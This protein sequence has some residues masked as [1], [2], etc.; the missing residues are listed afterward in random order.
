MMNIKKPVYKASSLEV[1]NEA[2]SYARAPDTGRHSIDFF[3][4]LIKVFLP[5]FLAVRAVPV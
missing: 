4:F 5:C 1:V 2:E 3:F